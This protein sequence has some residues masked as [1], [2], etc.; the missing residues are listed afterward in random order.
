MSTM[1][2]DP[3]PS[4]VFREEGRRHPA[5]PRLGIVADAVHMLL[6]HR[7]TRARGFMSGFLS[8][9][10]AMRETVQR[11]TRFSFPLGGLAGCHCGRVRVR[12]QT[13]ERQH[14][15]VGMGVERA[16]TVLEA[17]LIRAEPAR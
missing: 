12:R 16:L 13:A 14:D 9:S 6:V 10:P 15:L 4:W 1:S 2:F 11:K 7:A 17:K 8:G 5:C 3:Q